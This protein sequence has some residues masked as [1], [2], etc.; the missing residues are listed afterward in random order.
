MEELFA[1]EVLKIR[2][3][4][5][6]LARAL[7]G[8]PI[9]VLGNSSPIMKRVAGPGRPFSLWSGAIALSIQSQ[10]ILPASRTNSCFISMIWSSLA[11]NRSRDPVVVYL[12]GRIAPPM[13]TGRHASSPKGISKAKLQGSDA[14]GLKTLQ[15]QNSL[16]QELRL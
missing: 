14:Q 3:V 12:F 6:A 8:Q 5:P 9:N 7:I 13:R 11:R 2:I 10:S 16:Q 1:R 15:F 4:D